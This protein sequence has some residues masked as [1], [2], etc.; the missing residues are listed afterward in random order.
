MTVNHNGA[1]LDNRSCNILDFMDSVCPD[2][3]KEQK[4]L[5]DW[6]IGNIEDFWAGL[7]EWSGLRW[8]GSARRVLIGTDIETARFFPDLTLNFADNIL[9]PGFDDASGAVTTI[10]SDGEC[11]TFSRSELREVVERAAGSLRALGVRPGD[12]VVAIARNSVEAVIAALS[13]SAIGAVFSSAS[14]EMGAE[15]I[16]DRFA[17]L[18]PVVLFAN[19]VTRRSDRGQPLKDRVAKVI[20]GL[21]S[22]RAVVCLDPGESLEDEGGKFIPLAEFLEGP[23]LHQRDWP[24][25]AFDHP[26]YIMFSSGTTGRP[27]CIVHGT[28]GT[29]LEHIKEH[30][31]HCDLDSRDQLFFFTSCSWMM[32]NWQLSALGSGAG[33]VTFDGPVDEPGSLWR[34]VEDH[35]VTVFG[36]SPPYLRMCADAGFEP[37]KA[38]RLAA[39]RSI[40]STGS[41]L[42]DEQF[43]WVLEAVKAVPVQS[44]SGGTDILGCFVLGTPLLPVTRGEAQCRSLGLDVRALG[45]TDG[46]PVGEL[47]CAAP[48]PSRPTGFFGDTDGSRFHAAY[49]AANPGYWTHGDL[50]EISGEGGV[51]MHGRSDGILNI[52]GVRIGPAEISRILAQDCPEVLDSMAV[53]FR[54]KRGAGEAR[55]VLAVVLREGVVLDAALMARIRRT[56]SESATQAHVPHRIV[57]LPALPMTRNGKAST[58]ALSDAVNGLPVRNIAEI[59]NPE[60]LAGIEPRQAT[61][62]SAPRTYDPAALAAREEG[63]VTEFLRAEFAQILGDAS[64]SVDDNF[65]DFGGDSLMA[66]ELFTAI[67][68]ELG[69]D[70]PVSTLINAPTVRQIVGILLHGS[71]S[72]SNQLFTLREGEGRPLFLVHSLIGSILQYRHVAQLVDSPRP[73][74]AI[75]AHGLLPGEEPSTS[76][77]GM[78]KEYVALIKTVQ[79]EGPYSIGGYSLGG[80]IAFEIGRQ[81]EAEGCQT[82]PLFLIDPSFYISHAPISNKIKYYVAGAFDLIVEIAKSPLKEKFKYFFNRLN[83]S[84]LLRT[85]LPEDYYNVDQNESSVRFYDQMRRAFRLYRPN[86]Y[87]GDVVFIA[88]GKRLPFHNDQL[89]RNLVRGEFHLL[90]IPGDHSQMIVESASCLGMHMDAYLKGRPH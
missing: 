35:G 65:F 27:K 74:V 8:S 71:N 31:L 2:I 37:G 32:W 80:L 59:V 45:A 87:N 46:Q 6:S 58:A 19:M 84:M 16:L 12:R 33:I 18:E 10:G 85:F 75:Q 88:P 14:P 40:L 83:R 28:G 41:V 50:I 54:D 34:I 21:S 89:W 64:I 90:E 42:F 20:D 7:L 77:E 73:L 55:L 51:R 26:L 70:L 17:Q 86:S 5:Y 24:A 82:D 22:L 43:D 66:S 76:I 68:Q 25:F 61:G 13:A 72:A 38:F 79:P 48:F 57:T 1:T 9:N 4:H 60:V 44:I 47:V 78:A 23:A 67:S 30:R 53:E 81:L 69:V 15:S 3:I 29:L 62:P 63:A 56:L 39:L 36:T 49:F 11:R 52:R